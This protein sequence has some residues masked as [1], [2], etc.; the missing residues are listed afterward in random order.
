MS[1]LIPNRP[2]ERRGGR[3]KGEP[4]KITKMLKD[5]ILG[6]LD[7][8]GGEAYLVRQA[9][10]NPGAFM[11]LLGKVLPSDIVATMVHYRDVSDE[12]APEETRIARLIEVA[13]ENGVALQ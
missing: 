12:P 8:A 10:E 6:A 9:S 3:K 13:A 2:G 5:M 4:N 1:N 7:E 11:T